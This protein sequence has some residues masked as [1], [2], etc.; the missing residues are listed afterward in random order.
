MPSTIPPDCGVLT[1]ARLPIL[2]VSMPPRL[3]TV[4]VVTEA[5]LW[6]LKVSSPVPRLTFRVVIDW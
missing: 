5:V 2:K 6:M 3:A 1:P 4:V